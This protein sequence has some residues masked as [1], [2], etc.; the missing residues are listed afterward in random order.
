MKRCPFRR[1]AGVALAAALLGTPACSMTFDATHLGV[2]V[3]MA[4]AARAPAE[5]EPFKL[6]SRA[7][8]GLWGMVKFSEPSLEHSL[9][10]Q[11]VGGK[12]V[13]DLK[14]SVKSHFRDVLLTVLTAGLVVPRAVTFEGVIVE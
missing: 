6:T 4:S 12:E 1:L 5:G 8:Y 7:V 14:I 11:L 10:A 2:P 13:A 9:A 3:T